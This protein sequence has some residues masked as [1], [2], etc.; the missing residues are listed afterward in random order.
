[1]RYLEKSIIEVGQKG[2]L[3]YISFFHSNILLYFRTDR[4]EV[5]KIWSNIG[6]ER[7]DTSSLR[8]GHPFSTGYFGQ[9]KEVYSFWK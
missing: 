8:G 2:T 7:D 3:F 6:E 5:E 1:M 9:Y 4:V